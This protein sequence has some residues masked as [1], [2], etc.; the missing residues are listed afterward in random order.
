MRAVYSQIGR[1]AD[2][3][4]TVLIRGESG[5]GKELVARAIHHM[6]ARRDK[7]FIKVNCAALSAGLLESELFGHEKGSF[8]GA[9]DRK[10]G[11]FEL[12]NGG[13]LL[14]DEVSE[15]SIELQP[16]LLRALEDAGNPRLHL[17]LVAIH[18]GFDQPAEL[19]REQRLTN[20]PTVIVRQSGEEI[21]RI[22]ETPAA[23]TV[24]A[25]LAAILAGA[26]EP[27]RGRWQRD[28][29]IARGSYAYLGDGDVR[30]GGESWELYRTE[31]GGSLLHS[32]V[33]RGGRE[34]E[35][36]HRRGAGGAS[37]LAELTC[38]DGDRLSRTRIW[39]DDDGGLHSVT[40][41]NLTGI[42]DQSLEVP[43]GTRLLL[44]CAATSDRGWMAAGN[45]GSEST[46]TVFV[47]PWDQP[48]AGRLVELTSRALGRESVA[49][50][51]GEL[52]AEHIET[53]IGGETSQW[54]LDPELGLPLRA[55]V[56][57]IGRVEAEKIIDERPAG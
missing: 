31:N 23:E 7:P 51:A 44:P 9:H 26:A 15:I 18:R 6:S 1:V 48:A 53:R 45:A 13:T 10:V 21:G 20:V 5:T 14:L 28:Q 55:A 22:V 52:S 47:V 29:E 37:E 49:V 16:K 39:I 42:V 35:I 2:S 8:T 54:W 4:A 56:S 12:A 24:E 25:D 27:H 36:W 17:E 30:I 3:R 41:G 11:R 40:R 46:Q 43:P 50:E 34:I 19:I 57:E 32:T 33:E 38:R